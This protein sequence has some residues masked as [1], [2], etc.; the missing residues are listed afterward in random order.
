MA[1]PRS[2]V[3]ST[4]GRH[5]APRLASTI[6]AALVWLGF[7]CVVGFDGTPS[8]CAVRV[9]LS[10]AALAL[11]LVAIRRVPRQRRVAVELPLA[12]VAFPIGAAI[13]FSYLATSG[14]SVKAAG[15]AR[16]ALASVLH[17]VRGWRRLSA[18]PLAVAVLVL[19]WYPL[20]TAVYA[21]NVARPELGRETPARSRPRLSRCDVHH[22]RRRPCCPGGT[23]PR[24]TAPR[25]SCSTARRRPARACSARRRSLRDTAT[26][27]CCSTRAGTAAAAAGAWTSVGTA[28]ATSTLRSACCSHRPTSTARGSLRSASRWAERRRSGRWPR[29]PRSVR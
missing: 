20:A 5:G 10:A 11:F 12:I 29:S 14:V 28:T 15:A 21:T 3:P 23:S 22:L 6:G 25:S 16:R 2:V 9:L 27:C 8:W 19:A 13:S 1:E 17:R 7:G 18:V 24:R 26:A 4:R